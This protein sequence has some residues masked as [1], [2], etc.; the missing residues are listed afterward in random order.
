MASNLLYKTKSS[1]ASSHEDSAY[2]ITLVGDKGD[3]VGSSNKVEHQNLEEES[4]FA[5][6]FQQQHH[7]FR[8]G[9]GESSFKKSLKYTLNERVML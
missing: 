5:A 3:T 2:P 8:W 9:H 6:N 4:Q 1:D 7:R